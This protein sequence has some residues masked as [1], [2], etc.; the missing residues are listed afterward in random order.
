MTRRRGGRLRAPPA[1]AVAR[2]YLYRPGRRPWLVVR[3]VARQHIT[4]SVT[5]A[6]GAC[7]S[8][9]R[10]ARDGRGFSR[11]FPRRARA[12]PCGACLR[13]LVTVSCCSSPLSFFLVPLPRASTFRGILSAASTPRTPVALRLCSVQAAL[14]DPPPFGDRSTPRHFSRQLYA[15]WCQEP[16]WLEQQLGGASV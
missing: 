6:R 4:R 1:R 10:H 12:R 3:D 11:A 16:A 9:R 8:R 7:R 13:S 5:F 14:P 15:R 2:P